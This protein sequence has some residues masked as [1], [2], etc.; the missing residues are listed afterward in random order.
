MKAHPELEWKVT[1]GCL[2]IYNEQVK[3]LLPPF[4]KC[5]LLDMKDGGVGMSST[6]P[7]DV[8]DSVAAMCLIAQAKDQRVTAATAMNAGSSRSH[9]ILRFTVES[10]SPGTKGGGHVAVLNLVDLAGSESAKK[11]GAASGKRMREAATI[12]QSLLALGSVI[13][14]LSKEEKVLTSLRTSKLTFLLSPALKPDSPCL[15]TVVCTVRPAEAHA[16]ETGSTLEFAVKAGKVLTRPAANAA[17]EDPSESKVCRLE[18][19]VVRM[20]AAAVAARLEAEVAR[21]ETDKM[22]VE[23]GKLRAAVAKLQQMNAAAL[24]QQQGG[25]PQVATSRSSSRRVTLGGPPTEAEAKAAAHAAQE[26]VLAEPAAQ[27]RAAEAALAAARMRNEELEKTHAEAEAA[28]AAAQA[29]LA[30]ARTEAVAEAARAEDAAREADALRSA[31]AE[32]EARSS[33]SAAAAVAAAAAAAAAEAEKRS[34]AEAVRADLLS[35]EKA[36]LKMELDTARRQRDAAQEKAAAQK[37]AVMSASHER[38]S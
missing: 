28:K 17:R 18:E 38:H 24:V 14:A 36:K 30:E 31:A 3:D 25:P 1:L 29:A 19:D 6:S 10:R 11:T 15:T 4:A 5:E 20:S 21:A 27:L 37:L 2:E 34:V 16:R 23:V 26:P 32:A 12:K 8:A 9:V 35:G 13:E 7:S 22:T 33:E